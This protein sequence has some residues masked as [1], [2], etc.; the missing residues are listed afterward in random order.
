M[1]SAPVVA[2]APPGCTVTGPR[3]L[4]PGPTQRDCPAVTVRGPVCVVVM[5]GWEKPTVTSVGAAVAL[6]KK[7]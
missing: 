4:P 1:T 2:K 6:G 5:H 3:T 7:F